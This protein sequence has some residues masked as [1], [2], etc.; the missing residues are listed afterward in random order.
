MLQ[1]EDLDLE[2][3]LGWKKDESHELELEGELWP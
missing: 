2:V 3:F 1:L